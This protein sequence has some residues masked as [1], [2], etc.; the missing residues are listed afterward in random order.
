MAAAA[1]DAVAAAAAAAAASLRM[2]AL[3]A[4]AG[5]PEEELLAGREGVLSLSL[6]CS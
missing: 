4:L 6:L 3:R 5:R 1:A 2:S